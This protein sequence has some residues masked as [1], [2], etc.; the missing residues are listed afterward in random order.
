MTVTAAT[1]AVTHEQTTPLQCYYY[2]VKLEARV[3]KKK[4]GTE[5]VSMTLS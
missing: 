3:R 5:R 4:G 1:A 2:T